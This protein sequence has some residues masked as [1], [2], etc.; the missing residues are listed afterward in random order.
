MGSLFFQQLLLIVYQYSNWRNR[1]GG[2]MKRMEKK[3]ALQRNLVFLYYG[4]R[5][6]TISVV[7]LEYW[8]LASPPNQAPTN[9]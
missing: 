5:H 7:F 1:I 2:T 6:L 4:F 3:T 8:L 9:V